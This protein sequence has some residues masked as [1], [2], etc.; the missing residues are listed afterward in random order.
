M[1]IAPKISISGE[2]IAAAATERKFA[3]NRRCAALR[4]RAT[5]HDSMPKAFTMRLP[6]MVSCRMFC[7]S[8][9]WSCPV[10]VVERTR[11]PMRTAEKMMIGINI[12]STQASF[13]PRITTTTA[14]K[15]KVKN[16]CRNSART[17]DMANCTRSMSLM[18]VEIKVPV[19]C[20]WKK[21]AE[22]RRTE[23]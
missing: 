19:V 5:S 20:V 10:R 11:R 6:V 16:C 22:R 3:R 2:L 18:M 21:A 9:S 15:R 7:T 12:T 14:V 8:A 1:A 13:P 23:L 17:L 4:K